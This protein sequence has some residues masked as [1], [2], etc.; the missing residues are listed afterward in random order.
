MFTAPIVAEKNGTV[1]IEGQQAASQFKR[2][3][4]LNCGKMEQ[5]VQVTGD[6]FEFID[7]HPGTCE[8]ELRVRSK[9]GKLNVS[10]TKVIVPSVSDLRK[11]KGI[12]L[13]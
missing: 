1:R 10:Y 12:K 8:L 2:E 9:G 6:Y 13:K 7:H 5:F 3:A 4:H 11:V